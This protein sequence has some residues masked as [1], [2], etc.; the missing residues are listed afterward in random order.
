MQG[1]YIMQEFKSKSKH[2]RKCL[3][4]KMIVKTKRKVITKF[5]N[6]ISVEMIFNLAVFLN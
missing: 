5:R 2:L 6:Q 1:R 4:T 3:E